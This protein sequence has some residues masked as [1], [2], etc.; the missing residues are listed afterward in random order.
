MSDYDRFF[1]STNRGGVF[2]RAQCTLGAAVV[3]ELKVSNPLLPTQ[4]HDLRLTTKQEAQEA[5][6][7]VPPGTNGAVGGEKFRAYTQLRKAEDMVYLAWHNSLIVKAP[8]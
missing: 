1:F 5:L 4:S 7:Q 3:H 2:L 6:A 8:A